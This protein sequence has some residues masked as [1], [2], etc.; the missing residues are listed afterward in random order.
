MSVD[1]QSGLINKTAVTPANVPDGDALKHV[2]PDSGAVLAD[3]GYCYKSVVNVIKNKG[4]HDMT[5]K[6]NNMKNKNKDKDRW[7]SKLRS[8]YE[9]VFS[10]MERRARYRGEEKVQFQ[11]FMEGFAFNLKRLLKLDPK[12][13]LILN[14]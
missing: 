10:Q 11:M 1:T 13:E 3:K 4:C 8:P 6:K 2:C 5:I 7:I 12:G 14:L 9:R